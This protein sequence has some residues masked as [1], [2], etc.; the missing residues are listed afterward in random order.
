M[1]ML[2]RAGRAANSA[3]RVSRAAIRNRSGDGSGPR[4][5]QKMTTG[6][7]RE[8]V[9]GSKSFTGVVGHIVMQPPECGE[10]LT[11]ISSV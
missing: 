5:V 9:I 11:T 2:D 4:R 7:Q 6:V 10:M 3:S 1:R 8:Q